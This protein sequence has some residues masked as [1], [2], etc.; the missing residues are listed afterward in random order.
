M[1]KVKQEIGSILGNY[2][3]SLVGV[4]AFISV[5]LLWTNV[6]NES[7]FTIG[8]GLLVSIGFLAS[9]DSNK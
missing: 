9:K 2:K 6:I 5:G 7:Q 4:V 1:K 3:T 8:T